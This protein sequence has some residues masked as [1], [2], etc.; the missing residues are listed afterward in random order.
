MLP[1]R[2]Q[3]LVT[4]DAIDFKPGPLAPQIYSRRRFQDI[5]DVGAAYTRG[6]FEKVKIAIGIAADEFSVS[7]SGLHAHSFDQPAINVG[8]FFLLDRVVRNGLRDVCA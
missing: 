6:N 7:R 5:C 1:A 3:T 8:Q 2:T 4:I